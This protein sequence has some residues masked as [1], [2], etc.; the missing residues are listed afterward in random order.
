[1]NSA[2]TDALQDKL[3]N[4]KINFSASFSSS[5]LPCSFLMIFFH[6]FYNIFFFIFF[7]FVLPAS[8]R[9]QCFQ[10]HSRGVG[11]VG[12]FVDLFDILIS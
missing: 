7:N 2:G 11:H 10:F 3:I 9:Q 12:I 1:M 4:D 6:F 8:T 5:F